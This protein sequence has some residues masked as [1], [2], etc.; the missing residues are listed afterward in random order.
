[1]VIICGKTKSNLSFEIEN[2]QRRRAE[3]GFARPNSFNAMSAGVTHRH[4]HTRRQK[5]YT[6]TYMHSHTHTH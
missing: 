2:S 4:T 1:M 5:T 3:Y 6:H